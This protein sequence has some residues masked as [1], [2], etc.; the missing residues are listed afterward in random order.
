MTV[1]L[2]DSFNLRCNLRKTIAS[3]DLRYSLVQ[4]IF[5]SRPKISVNKTSGLADES[6]IFF[7]KYHIKHEIAC[8][9]Y[10]SVSAILWIICGIDQRG[11][12]FFFNYTF[13]FCTFL[14]CGQREERTPF[15]LIYP[16]LKVFFLANFEK[17]SKSQKRRQFPSQINNNFLNEM[18]KSRGTPK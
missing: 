9:H 4:T 14:I 6:K 2:T 13:L 10:S 17:F 5:A 3:V 8:R 15:A 12:K 1:R 7:N 11:M 16:S 18:Q